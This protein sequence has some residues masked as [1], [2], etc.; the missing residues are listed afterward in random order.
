MPVVRP[1][2]AA[3]DVD[4][5]RLAGAV[6]A[7]QPDDLAAAQLERDA[8]AAPATPSNERETEE[9]RSVSPGLVSDS[10]CGSAAK[11]AV[12]SSGRPWRRPCRRACGLLFWILITRYCRP[13]TVWQLRREADEA[14]ERRHLLE[15]LH[16]RGE[17]RAVRRAARPL[18]RG[19]DTVDR[20]RAGDEAAR[21][22]VDLLG[23]LVDGRR[24]GRRRTT[25]A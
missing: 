19:D 16:L 13:N 8:A 1:V 25:D 23:E 10:A 17:R 4:E 20:G 9:A 12:R 2:E 5:R 11:P 3:E 24:S 14:R 7:D 6:R 15:L 21:A 22:G 18:D